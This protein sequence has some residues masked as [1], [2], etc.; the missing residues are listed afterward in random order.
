M[1][2]IIT[3]F[4]P[5]PTGNPH[6]GNIRTALFAYLFAK[7]NNGKFLLRI[8]DTDRARFVPESL[9]YIEESLKWLGLGY[10]GEKKFQSDRLKSYQKAAEELVEKDLAY[11]CF[12]SVERLEELRKEQEAKKL[13]PGYDRCCRS[14]T[15]EEAA[16][17]EKAGEKYVIRFKMPDTGKAVWEDMVRGKI[18]IEYS[19][20]DD[21]IILKA[22]GWPTYHLANIIDDHEMNITDVIRGEEWIPSTP[23]HVALYNAFGWEK[24][25]FGHL[26]VILGGD[27]AKLSKR[28]GDTAILDYREKGY[29]AEAL[30]NF[31]ALLG[32]NPGTT[33]EI[34]S[35]KDLEKRFD[36]ARVQK[37][38]A[39]FDVERLNWLNGQY[40]RS[41]DT[42]ELKEKVVSLMPDL[43][44]LKLPNSD[45]VLTVEK[46]RLTTLKDLEKD[47]DFYI[48]L[49]VYYPTLL[50][51]KKST[52]EATKKGLEAALKAVSAS[53]LDKLEVSEIEKLL[54]DVVAAQE[55]SNGDVFWPV[56]VTLTGK[57]KSPSPAEMLWVFGK[58]ESIKRIKVGLEKL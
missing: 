23:K 36:L 11:K 57:E 46:T 29:L 56:R 9:S 20:Q 22:D 51:F 10:D 50:V 41:L 26:P 28:H 2:E 47:T 55:L 13:A 42:D 14:L 38:P 58:E 1:N 12:C 53:D 48:S 15:K 25:N 49:P 24:P 7:K 21:P 37:A 31:L 45:R 3:R 4:A 5:S 40:I 30:V 44:L 39:V 19:T 34:F 35:L 54:S 6:V 16:A 27:K 52:T 32:W 43:D 18:E 33:E 17:K 8:E